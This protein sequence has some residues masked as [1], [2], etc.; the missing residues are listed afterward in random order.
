MER[1]SLRLEA[2]EDED[3]TQVVVREGFRPRP[4]NSTAQLLDAFQDGAG[5][6]IEVPADLQPEFM[7]T[8][9]DAARAAGRNPASELA[10]DALRNEASPDQSIRGRATST[11]PGRCRGGTLSDRLLKPGAIG[12]TSRTRVR[13]RWSTNWPPGLRRCVSRSRRR[14]RRPKPCWL[15]RLWR[16]RCRPRFSWTSCCRCGARRGCGSVPARS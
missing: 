16:R 5:I 7:R 2:G 8:W 3:S 6:E 4:S 13:R 1:R 9:P 15:R 12:R 14:S 10:T 11:D